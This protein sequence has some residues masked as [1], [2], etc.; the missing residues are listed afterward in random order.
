M[1]PGCREAGAA[2]D[3]YQVGGGQEGL[4]MPYMPGDGGCGLP[5]LSG[6][7]GGVFACLEDC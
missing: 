2:L 3:A 5:E 1:C 4:L 6:G 7:A